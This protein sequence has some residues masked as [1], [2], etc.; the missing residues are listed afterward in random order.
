MTITSCTISKSTR[1]STNK[2]R[3]HWRDERRAAVSRVALSSL[4]PSANRRECE[5]V[6][7]PDVSGTVAAE[8]RASAGARVSSLHGE[9]H[10]LKFSRI[11][12][13]GSGKPLP[14]V[15]A[16]NSTITLAGTVPAT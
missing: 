6:D 10:T 5:G 15:P 11:A 4:Q 14:Y 8:V 16:V 2:R 3:D 7:V 1:K 9:G 13:P 12:F